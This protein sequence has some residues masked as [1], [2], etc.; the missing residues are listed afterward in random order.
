[1]HAQNHYQFRHMA[2]VCACV[3][4]CAHVCLCMNTYFTLRTAK[5]LVSV[6]CLLLQYYS[7][8]RLVRMHRRPRKWFVLTD[9]LIQH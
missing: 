2:Y 1:M 9:K 5:H 8:R 4:G 3:N 7:G 6:V